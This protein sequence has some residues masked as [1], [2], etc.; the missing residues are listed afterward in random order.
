MARR[1]S[2]GGP[3]TARVRAAP[4][5]T[6]PAAPAGAPGRAAV[7]LAPSNRARANRT[8]MTAAPSA[9]LAP[10]APAGAAPAVTPPPASR[11]V[12]P[13]AAVP[14]PADVPAQAAAPAPAA[15][16][17][18]PARAA[19]IL[20]EPLSLPSIPDQTS[21]AGRNY[22][23]MAI[24]SE[25][26][27]PQISIDR[28]GNV[29]T[30]QNAPAGI[31]AAAV[32]TSAASAVT[33]I[34][35]ITRSSTV[36]MRPM[37]ATGDAAPQ[38]ASNAGVHA[39][40]GSV[41]V[42]QPI[43]GVAVSGKLAAPASG[44]PIIEPNGMAAIFDTP[45]DGQVMQAS[46]GGAQF[47]VSLSVIP[48]DSPPSTA[49]ISCTV[50][51]DAQ[52]PGTRNV[53][54]TSSGPDSSGTI[55][56]TGSAPL[57]FNASGSHTLTAVATQLS[58]TSSAQIGFTVQLGAGGGGGGVPVP[59]LTIASPLN[60]TV[61]AAQFGDPNSPPEAVVTFTGSATPPAGAAIQSVQVQ[62]GASATTAANAT[63]DPS[64]G[65]AKWTADQVLV[66]YGPQTA[67]VTVMASNNTSVTQ[68]VN[69][70]LAPFEPRLWLYSKLVIIED[71][72]VTN[73]PRQY[74]RGKVL[75]T[76]SLLPGETT[77]I[78]VSSYSTSETTTTDTSSIF[79]ELSDNTSS[80][81]DTSIA[82]EQTDKQSQTDS[83]AWGV[84]AKASASWGWGSAD[85]SG[86]Y[87]SDSNSAREDTRKAV[88]AA[89]EKHAAQRSSRRS[90]QVN[91]E[92]Q[93]TS[94][95]GTTQA[96]SRQITNINVSRTLN[97]IFYQLNQDYVSLLHLVDTRI[98]Y[99]S[100]FL[101]LLDGTTIFDYQEV[102]VSDLPLL[103]ATA[104]RS[105]FQAEVNG[106]VNDVLNNVVDYADVRHAL[107]ETVVP[108]DE[109]TGAPAPEA[110]YFRFRRNL[111]GSWVDP[112][113]GETRTVPGVIIGVTT[114]TMRT[115]GVLVDSALGQ[116]LAIDDYN[117]GLQNASLAQRQLANAA[118]Q[119]VIDL[120]N[121]PDPNKTD[122]WQ[123]THPQS[124]P[125]TL[126]IAAANP[127]AAGG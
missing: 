3:K 28:N 1:E 66:G 37:A 107:T 119:Q 127:P 21:Y 109:V 110:A 117:V 2:R 23:D 123:K 7:T 87:K 48:P 108:T 35:Q 6:I 36:V 80:D 13:A 27:V 82:D 74:G 84:A 120:V 85:I 62:I 51:L 65:W 106:N 95:T 60:G 33:L 58:K 71:M 94:T 16:A 122:A 24:A 45:T 61:I 124:L 22:I 103:L 81:Y 50:T 111:S 20:P 26:F 49:R 73:F 38:L 121:N 44:G 113:T 126:S 70:V 67:T 98:G 40:S 125:A 29:I 64:A 112:D 78:S 8:P 10:L 116:N 46:G 72:R 47:T 9:S 42:R 53:P 19:A 114:V 39:A 55:T 34:S 101:S 69:L 30:P 12:A 76:F 54:V 91:A 32:A 105:E 68:T 88:K 77:N 89:T 118:A 115:D 56:F 15:G 57:T 31:F 4:E 14:A 75:R 90:I 41:Q 102:T 63:P 25:K 79:D 92:N 11:V 97:F 5:T 52:T 59:A 100:A 43:G 104:I 86:N 18:P 93:Q 17:A 99:V 96:I 83:T